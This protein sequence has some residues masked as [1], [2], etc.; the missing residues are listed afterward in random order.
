MGGSCV[1]LCLFIS[2]AQVHCGVCALPKGA[3]HTHQ[4]AAYGGYYRERWAVVVARNG[5]AA[6]VCWWWCHLVVLFQFPRTPSSLFCSQLAP[7]LGTNSPFS[8]PSLDNK[9]TQTTRLL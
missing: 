7:P 1:P 6:L 2:V 4:E 3:C 8:L 9:Q 5:T